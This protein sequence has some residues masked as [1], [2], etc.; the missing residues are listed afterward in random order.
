MEQVLPY[1]FIGDLA[2]ARDPSLLPVHNIQN[3]VSVGCAL[4]E[5]ESRTDRNILSFADIHDT[6]ETSIVT[7]FART[8]AFIH[9]AITTKRP[10]LV[11][12]VYGQ[13]RSAAVVISYLLSIGHGLDDAMNLVKSVRP[14]ICIN[15]GFLAQLYV[16]YTKGLDSTEVRSRSPPP[17]HTLTK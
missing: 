15:P 11:H 5:Q 3:I 16:V 8:N 14:V 6:P 7:I 2:S 1:L 17:P 13:S 10:V 12:C 9:T 4:V